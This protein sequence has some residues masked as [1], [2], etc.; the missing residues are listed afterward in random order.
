M[1][2]RDINEWY[3][4]NRAKF[5]DHLGEVTDQGSFIENSSWNKAF[6]RN[7]EFTIADL[8]SEFTEQELKIVYEILKVEFIKCSAADCTDM[9][10]QDYS[11]ISRISGLELCHDC[12]RKEALTEWQR[13]K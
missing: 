4:K 6:K 2:G 9:I 12:G 11:A 8:G 1:T 13:S 10:V 5:L 3:R 7:I